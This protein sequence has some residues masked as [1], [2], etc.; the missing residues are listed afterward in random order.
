LHLDKDCDLKGFKS[1]IR[2][3]FTDGSK[4]IIAGRQYSIFHSNASETPVIFRLFAESGVGI[5][6]RDNLSSSQ[7]ADYC[8]PSTL[9]ELSVTKYMKRMKLCFTLTTPSLSLNLGE[10]TAIPDIYGNNGCIMTDGCGLISR[11]A[12]N[13]V[14]TEYTRNDE[15]RIRSLGRNFTPETKAWCPYSSFQ[16]RIGG[17]KGMFVLDDSLKGVRVQYRPSQVSMH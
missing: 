16:G 17:I 13:Q 12:L 1:N 5:D 6:E 10:L 3:F 9:N 11:D 14:W 4:L 7:L 2:R 15:D 8:I